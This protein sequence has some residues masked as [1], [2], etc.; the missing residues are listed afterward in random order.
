MRKLNSFARSIA[1]FNQTLEEHFPLVPYRDCLGRSRVAGRPRRARA[2][3]ALQ[4][5]LQ[6]Q[7]R[8]RSGIVYAGYELVGAAMH[9]SRSTAYRAVTDLRRASLLACQS[10]GGKTH[11][12]VGHVVEA[13]NGYQVP[14]SLRGRA[15]RQH[16]RPRAG[17]PSRDRVTPGQR[18]AEEILDRH[19]ESR[20]GPAA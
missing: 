13:A 12:E 10:G 17:K 7:T 18:L 14:E 15:D 5:L 16:R 8:S 3:S 2:Q 11:D 6:L 19:R 1:R 4:A 9:R 20:A